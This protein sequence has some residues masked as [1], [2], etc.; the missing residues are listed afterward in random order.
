GES[1]KGFHVHPFH[2]AKYIREAIL[3]NIEKGLSKSNRPRAD[4]ALSSAIFVATNDTEKEMARAQISFYASTPTYRPVLEIHGWGETGEHLSALAARGKWAEMPTQITD[5]ML[6]EFAVIAND[7]AELVA[8]IK[9]RY[10]G[11]M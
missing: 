9:E 7:D 3:P 4:I 2:T 5:E 6:N 8:R 11:L 1:G 10:T